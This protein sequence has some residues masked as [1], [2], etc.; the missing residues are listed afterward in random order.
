[1]I[2]LLTE[3]KDEQL[4]LLEDLDARLERLSNANN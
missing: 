1:M 4:K 3:G 2:V